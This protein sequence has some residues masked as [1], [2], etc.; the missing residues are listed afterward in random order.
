MNF[1]IKID[2]KK[3][4]DFL[5]IMSGH[6]GIKLQLPDIFSSTDDDALRIAQ[7]WK[8]SADELLQLLSPYAV[9][10]FNDATIVY[11][12]SL[13]TNWDVRQSDNLSEYC[14]AYV[15][16]ELFA[17]WLDYIKPDYASLQRTLGGAVASAIRRVLALRCP[18][19]R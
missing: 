14:N 18:P 5:H 6:L 11:E 19:A 13:P 16:Y 12:L 8:M 2:K 17:L 10:N 15:R 4:I 7:M 1:E 9:M 3:V